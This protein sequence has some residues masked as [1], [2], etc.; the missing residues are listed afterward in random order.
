MS[1]GPL[2]QRA[3]PPSGSFYWNQP[4]PVGFQCICKNGKWK[5]KHPYLHWFWENSQRSLLLQNPFQNLLWENYFC[6]TRE[7][8]CVAAKQWYFQIKQSND[9]P[10]CGRVGAMRACSSF[11]PLPGRAEQV[12]KFPHVTLYQLTRLST[13]RSFMGFFFFLTSLSFC[14]HL[15]LK[16]ERKGMEGRIANIRGFWKFPFYATWVFL[17]NS[18]LSVVFLWFW[19]QPLCPVLPLLYFSVLPALC[20]APGD[21]GREDGDSHCL[22]EESPVWILFFFKLNPWT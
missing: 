15:I 17:K 4:V 14:H 16:L 20:R 11:P 8:K 10:E 21:A 19:W 7:R 12:W 5:G 22:G 9:V 13:F 2:R 18:S 1:T 3:S 6:P